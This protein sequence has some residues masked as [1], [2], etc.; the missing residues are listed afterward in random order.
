MLDVRGG[1]MTGHLRCCIAML[2]TRRVLVKNHPSLRPHEKA[3]IP[4][5]R[6]EKSENLRPFPQF[7]RLTAPNR[8]IPNWRSPKCRKVAKRHSRDEPS[9]KTAQN[10]LQRI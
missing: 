4:H 3:P 7:A 5:S 10:R 8:K 2:K 9:E 6:R 1:W